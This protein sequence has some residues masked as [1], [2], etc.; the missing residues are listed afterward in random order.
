MQTLRQKLLS[1]MMAL[2]I[3]C[4]VLLGAAPSALA[5]TPAEFQVNSCGENGSATANSSLSANEYVTLKGHDNLTEC[6]VANNDAKVY[7][8]QVVDSASSPFTR[9]IQV[10]AQGPAAWYGGSMYL[11][12]TD[13]TGDCYT[14]SIFRR[15]RKQHE[16][17]YMSDSPIK[18]IEWGNYGGG[19]CKDG[20]GLLK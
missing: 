11:G 9:T 3:V 19:V 8:I 20:T 14:L 7:S 2:A 6:I 13:D 15:D 5:A 16:V 10:D 12:F 17:S 4:T 18:K 1:A